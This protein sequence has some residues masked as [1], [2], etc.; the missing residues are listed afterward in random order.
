MGEQ[1]RFTPDELK[2]LVKSG[3]LREVMGK[4]HPD[5]ARVLDQIQT[6]DMEGDFGALP[7]ALAGLGVGVA[8][9]ALA[10]EVTAGGILTKALPYGKAAGHGIAT[11][12]GMEAGSWGL[13]KL[14]MPNSLSEMLPLMVMMTMGGGKGGGAATAEAGALS[15]A[16]KLEKELLARGISPQAA[17]QAESYTAR[18]A[19]G[20]SAS[21]AR[22]AA[23]NPVER[24][25]PQ[26]SDDLA[27]QVGRGV[28]NDFRGP[29]SIQ[30]QQK[31]WE[32]IN[33]RDAYPSNISTET[34]F[35]QL[36]E[37]LTGSS[38]GRGT[39]PTPVRYNDPSLRNSVDRLKKKVARRTPG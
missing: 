37:M 22:P 7:K 31:Q 10:P 4:L 25:A 32:D 16:Q 19:A 18:R 3:R 35:D 13:K 21:A 8:A 27:E 24:V 30:P 15:E 28:Q 14:G 5:D 9:G 29:V 20:Q 33:L 17:S 36:V 2:Y 6:G 1:V 23:Y 12:A 38:H 26:M 34:P 11:L 39:S